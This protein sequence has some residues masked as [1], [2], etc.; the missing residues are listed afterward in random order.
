MA[1]CHLAGNTEG[2]PVVSV[3]MMP[4]TS[5]CGG[6]R[7]LRGDIAIVSTE[8]GN[9]GNSKKSNEESDSDRIQVKWKRDKSTRTH[10]A[11]VVLRRGQL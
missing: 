3:A 4:Q 5:A 1:M 7:S 10:S 6:L 11:Y 8:T 2:H 9:G